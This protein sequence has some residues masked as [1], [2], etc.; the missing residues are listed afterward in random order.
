MPGKKK[1]PKQGKTKGLQLDNILLAFCEE[2]RILSRYLL[3]TT[4]ADIQS[5]PRKHN[6]FLRNCAKA[7][8]L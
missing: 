5:L 4:C 7:S 1:K 3:R 2:N 6:S 8:G